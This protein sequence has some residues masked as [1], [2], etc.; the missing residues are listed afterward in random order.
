[1]LTKREPFSL[2]RLSSWI[3]TQRYLAQGLFTDAR[4]SYSHNARTHH[5]AWP[6]HN[7]RFQSLVPASVLVI[8]GLD[9][10]RL[11]LSQDLLLLRCRIQRLAVA[12]VLVVKSVRIDFGT[13]NLPATRWS[14][15][16]G[17]LSHPCTARRIRH[18]HTAANQTFDHDTS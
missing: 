2:K 18:H 11:E 15:H 5:V 7:F 17:H 3:Y 4:S 13:S 1:M 9:K 6:S 12:A 10:E 16:H 8:R 14:F